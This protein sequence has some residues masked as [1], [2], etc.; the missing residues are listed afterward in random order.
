MRHPAAHLTLG[1]VA[2]VL[3]GWGVWELWISTAGATDLEAVRSVAGERS[4]TVVGGSS[5]PSG[6]PTQAS[7]LWC[8]LVVAM[9]AAGAPRI[10]TGFAAGLAL[11]LVLAVT[12]S[13]AYIGVYYP[14]NVVAGMLSAPVGQRSSRVAC[15]R[16]RCD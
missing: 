3:V 5:F 6:H 8:S 13:R 10:A 11:L 2:F 12:G 4:T 15:E 1:L 9:A 16:Q 14:G 7:A